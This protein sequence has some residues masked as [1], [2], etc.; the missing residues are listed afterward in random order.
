MKIVCKS[1]EELEAA[2]REKSIV[3]S[4]GNFNVSEGTYEAQDFAT[5]AARGTSCVKLCSRTSG[6]GSESAHI[7]A[8]SGASYHVQDNAEAEAYAGSSGSCSIGGV[9]R[10][11][12]V[13]SLTVDCG[14][15]AYIGEGVVACCMRDGTVYARNF[16][17][18]TSKE[19]SKVFASRFAVVY[20]EPGAEVDGGVQIIV[21]PPTNGKEWAEDYGAVIDGDTL[22]VA[23]ASYEYGAT[24]NGVVYEVGKVV[25]APDWDGGLRECGGGLHFCATHREAREYIAGASRFFW[26]AIPADEISIIGNPTMPNKIKVSSCYVLAEC[27]ING[28]VIDPTEFIV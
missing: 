19:G 2:R 13:C 1:Q 16:S 24:T 14:G 12:G 5:V 27:D 28:N 21:K 3:L 18:V 9:I 7:V 6:T 25:I 17:Q 26:C 8:L 20:V 11:K 4:G 10:A 22:I 23:K 15:I